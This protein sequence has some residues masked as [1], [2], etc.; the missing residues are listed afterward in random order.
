MKK[1]DRA[2]QTEVIINHSPNFSSSISAGAVPQ[3]TRGVVFTLS[4]A[5]AI[6]PPSSDEEAE[7]EE[8]EEGEQQVQECT[9]R[10]SILKQE[11]SHE[12]SL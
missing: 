2:C 1:S 9:H 3:N 5:L 4:K 12:D 6:D 8:E 10:V 7:N 11:E